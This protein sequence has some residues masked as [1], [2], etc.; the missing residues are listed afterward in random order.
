[1]PAA[2]APF[3]FE[4]MCRSCSPWFADYVNQA[5][6]RT[7]DAAGLRQAT[8]TASHV[9]RENFGLQ[10]IAIIAMTTISGTEIAVHATGPH[11]NTHDSVFG[12]NWYR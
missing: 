10:M 3:H 2:V 12:W 1:M 7:K 9:K 5:N 11:D 4:R 8:E 6:N